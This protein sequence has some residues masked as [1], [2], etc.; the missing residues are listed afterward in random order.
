MVL[1]DLADLLSS[2]GLGTVGASIYK[3]YTPEAGDTPVLTLYEYAGGQP[4]R[5]MGPNAGEDPAEAVAVQVVVRAGQWDYEAARDLAHQAWKQLEGLPERTIN[6][7]RY[8]YGSARQSPF[9]M[10]RDP[11][12]RVL[13]AC[14]YDVLKEVS[15]TS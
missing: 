9:L 10:G 7:V 14:N 13:I 3:G 8:L 4:V 2:G 15:T 1:D 5:A 6:G 11:Q 12:G